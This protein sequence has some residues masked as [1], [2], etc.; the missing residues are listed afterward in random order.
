MTGHR[1]TSGT[2]EAIKLDGWRDCWWYLLPSDL[3]VA[4]SEG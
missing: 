4:V 2:W 3:R 1:P